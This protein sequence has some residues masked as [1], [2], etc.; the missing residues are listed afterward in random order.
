MSLRYCRDRYHSYG[1]PVE[2]AVEMQQGQRKRKRAT[3][4]TSSSSSSSFWSPS[5]SSS[6]PSLALPPSTSSSTQVPLAPRQEA[7]PSASAA[8][9]D[10]GGSSLLVPP[11]TVIDSTTTY[12]KPGFMVVQQWTTI[13]ESG[14]TIVKSQITV[15][16]IPASQ[17]RLPANPV[18]DGSGIA[19]TGLLTD[20]RMTIP[21][22]MS[23]TMLGL[24]T[25]TG[26]A[27]A[28]GTAATDA[29][30]KAQDSGSS[31]G[32]FNP[33][34]I[35]IVVIV[36]VIGG[37]IFTTGMFCYRR[38]KRLQ[39]KRLEEGRMDR[40]YAKTSMAQIDTTGP[41]YRADDWPLPPP[42]ATTREG[43]GVHA[44]TRKPS[45]LLPSPLRDGSY[46]EFPVPPTVVRKMPSRPVPPQSQ[47]QPR[48][49]APQPS[50]QQPRPQSWT[51][52]QIEADTD[53]ETQPHAYAPTQTNAYAPASVP[54]VSASRTNSGPLS[55][56]GSAYLR[57]GSGGKGAYPTADTL[58]SGYPSPATIHSP[59]S[60]H[61]SF[62]SMESA[63]DPDLSFGANG[64]RIS[65]QVDTENQQYNSFSYWGDY[66]FSRRPYSN[67]RSVHDSVNA[68]SPRLTP[69]GE[70]SIWEEALMD[71]DFEVRTPTDTNGGM[72]SPR[73]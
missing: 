60:L 66:D 68:A 38:K 73:P 56:A 24:P 14:S 53:V 12:T 58:R 8:P 22:A 34:L 10:G 2:V 47:P 43:R 49:W 39:Q 19:P 71:V 44:I 5:S 21:P 57:V 16:D 7:A 40:E 13:T 20:S 59:S 50:Q 63:I 51:W 31:N 18:V 36:V 42:L 9:G 46:P 27:R 52:I 30:S 54:P 37:L 48:S 70:N 69:L 17:T 28:T 11:S 15:V 41:D 29:R 67:L 65:A 4:S 3:S 45:T 25:T 72:A 1:K 6:Q 61:K 23:S 33:M 26:P 55:L 35:F 64:S 32:G 62:I